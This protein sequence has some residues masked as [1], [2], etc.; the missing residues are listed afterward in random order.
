MAGALLEHAEGMLDKGIH[1]MRVAEGYE[2]ASEI[3]TG[4]LQGI[5]ETFVID[6][7]NVEP[8]IQTAMATLSSK[9]YACLPLEN[10]GPERNYAVALFPREIFIHLSL[11]SHFDSLFEVASSFE[12]TIPYQFLS[13]S[14]CPHSQAPYRRDVCEGHHGCCRPRP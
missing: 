5:A 3:A 7:N 13:G 8:L 14:Q 4:H 9:M 1:P 11:I 12:I 2:R 6:K 10:D